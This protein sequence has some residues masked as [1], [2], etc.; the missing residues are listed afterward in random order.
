MG[1]Y[2]GKFGT[3]TKPPVGCRDSP[4]FPEF[5]ELPG[6]LVKWHSGE[7]ANFLDVLILRG[8]AYSHAGGSNIK[9][10]I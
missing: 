2:H 3:S 6:F 8:V 7:V 10:I 4:E 9:R 5:P 1:T